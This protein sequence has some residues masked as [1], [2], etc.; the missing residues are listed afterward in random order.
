MRVCWDS[1]LVW[2]GDY[3]II[4]HADAAWGVWKRSVLR[5]AETEV[6][7]FVPNLSEPEIAGSP[8]LLSR[9]P[10]EAWQVGRSLSHC[11][12]SPYRKR[13]M[14]PDVTSS[15]RGSQSVLYTSL[16]FLGARVSAA[17]PPFKQHR[18]RASRLNNRLRQHTA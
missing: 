12:G 13:M 2:V 8:P 18:A 17:C 4:Q 11:A 3:P 15:S 10:T 5:R 14:T 9:G 16:L 1:R 6:M 7:C